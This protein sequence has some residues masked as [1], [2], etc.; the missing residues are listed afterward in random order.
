MQNHFEKFLLPVKF[1]ID[2]DALEQKYFAFQQ[3]F[4]PDRAGV[5]EIENSMDINEAYA[6][7]KNPLRRAMHILQ[8]NGINLEEDGGPVKPDFATL[9]SVLEIQEK[10]LDSSAQEIINLKKELAVKIKSSINDAASE[11]EN[12]DF[13]AAAQF[14]IKAKYFDKVLCDLK[15]LNN[16]QPG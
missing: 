13:K 12:K 11:L 8:L 7:L 15:N 3:Q 16:K 2:D 10:I 4:H 1:S 6:V 14:L 9:E 5:A